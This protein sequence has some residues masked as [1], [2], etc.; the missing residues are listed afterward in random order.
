MNE[1]RGNAC[2]LQAACVE[3]GGC[4]TELM[5]LTPVC[6]HTGCVAAAARLLPVLSTYMF[7]FEND[8]CIC[9]C[10]FP[11]PPLKVQENSKEREK[12]I[13]CTGKKKMP[14]TCC[15]YSLHVC[16]ISYTYRQ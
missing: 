13:E 2:T 4:V 10:D 7:P 3:R 14:F 11:L 8:K 16:D 6:V 15:V 9:L 12:K 5:L 1:R